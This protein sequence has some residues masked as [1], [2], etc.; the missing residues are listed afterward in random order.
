[1]KITDAKK[2]EVVLIDD[3][4]IL[5][6]LETHR[7]MVKLGIHAPANQKILTSTD[8]L[9]DGDEFVFIANAKSQ[10]KRIDAAG[11]IQA[12]PARVK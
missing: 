6:V 5:V 9:R 10:R 8:T 7:G 3:D 11:G 4:V 12:N 2:G 1:M